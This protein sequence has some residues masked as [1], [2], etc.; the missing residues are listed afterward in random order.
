MNG[1]L[2][3]T[4]QGF[5]FYDILVSEVV[6]T[7][8]KFL[9]KDKEFKIYKKEMENLLCHYDLIHNTY[10]ASRDIMLI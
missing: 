5:P 1:S 4:C 10:S 2:I 7:C 6:Q 8:T 3:L 9:D